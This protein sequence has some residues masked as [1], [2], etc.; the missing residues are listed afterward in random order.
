VG[1]I[2]LLQPVA[3][4]VKLFSRE[5]IKLLIYNYIIYYFSPLF[6]FLCILLLW[7][8]YPWKIEN[9]LN[10][11]L[12]YFICISRLS[13]Y[14]ILLAG[15]R[16]NRKYRLLGSY[17]GVAQSISYEVRLSFILLSL[18]IVVYEYSLMGIINFQNW[19]YLLLGIFII[20]IIWIMVILAETNRTP[21][22]FSEG[23][24]ELV[25][26]FNVEY[27]SG[28]F[29]LLFMAEYGNI[30]FIG[31][32]SVILFV[33][34]IGWLSIFIIIYVIFFLWVRGTLAR[35]RYDN[36]I[37]IAWKILLPYSIYIFLIIRLMA[38][39]FE[40]INW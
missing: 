8:L 27:G 24:S 33:G 25:S 11:G 3:D 30:I 16:S 12:V 18:V 22:D 23:E 4:A 29:A 20:I 7:L 34:N 19:S 26:G 32:L 21:F 6:G 9:Y 31:I 13:V 5:K 14:V 37:I 40:G 36:L 38:L 10:F 15:W 1:I 35:F 2:G 39:I 17:R 28:L